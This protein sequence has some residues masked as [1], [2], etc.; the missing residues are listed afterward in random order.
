MGTRQRVFDEQFE[1]CD[2]KAAV[3]KTEISGGVKNPHDPDAQ[4]SSKDTANK[5]AWVG[6]KAQIAETVPDGE[7]ASTQP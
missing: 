6:Y 2:Q 4:W 5:T 3:R 7:D 1:V